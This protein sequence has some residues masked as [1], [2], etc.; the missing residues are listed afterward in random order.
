MYRIITTFLSMLCLLFGVS[1]NA[2][3]QAAEQ[4]GELTIKIRQT[5]FPED[6]TKQQ[7]RVYRLEKGQLQIL[8]EGFDDPEAEVSLLQKLTP[9]SLDLLRQ[10]I[11]RNRVMSNYI[12][13]RVYTPASDTRLK[14]EMMISYQGQRKVCYSFDKGFSNALRDLLMA[15]NQ[16]IPVG[17]HQVKVPRDNLKIMD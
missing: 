1:L 8:I 2:Q 3:E 11:E 10:T 14:T 9:E 7:L 17:E 5:V 6:F 12:D 4:Q 16:V 15:L 13:C